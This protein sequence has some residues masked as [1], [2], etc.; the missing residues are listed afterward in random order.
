MTHEE[1]E[2]DAAARNREADADTRFLVREDPTEGWSVVRMHGAGL[3][4]VRPTGTRTEARPEPGEPPDPR[5]SLIRN[6][7]P[8]GGGF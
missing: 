2:A 4:A 3:G 8:Y 1:A 7:P 6:V 5:S